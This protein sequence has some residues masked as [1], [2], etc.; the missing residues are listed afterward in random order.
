[1]GRAGNRGKSLG[2]SLTVFLAGDAMLVRPWSQVTRPAFQALIARMRAADAAILNLETVLHEFEDYAQADSGGTWTASQPAIAAELAWAGVDLLG[3]ANNHSFD[4]GAGGVLATHRHAEKAG[5]LIAGSGRDLQ[6]ARAPRCLVR[7]GGV[8]ALV[9]AAA[10]FVRYG[11]AS[12]SRADMRGRPGVN[13]LPLRK[14]TILHA[15]TGL[16]RLLRRAGRGV[17]LRVAKGP[18]LRLERGLRA[19]SADL[20]ANL[21]AIR[22]AAAT[23][24]VA[25]F[26]LHAHQHGKWL[27]Q[28]AH[29]A[30]EA[31]A[32][33]VLVHGP[34]RV[35]GVELYKGS[36]IFYGLGDFAYEPHCIDRF[37][38]EIYR[39]DGL[40]PDA[41][42]AEVRA[43]VRRSTLSQ[44]RE[45]FEGCAAELRFVEGRLSDV[46]LLPLDLG[47]DLGPEERGRPELA[48]SALGRRII[49][50]MARQSAQYRARVV[51]DA[52]RNEGLVD[53]GG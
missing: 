34:H 21:A 43:I 52:G 23:S 3:H 17:G 49:A 18:R 29:R 30:V 2:R 28:T 10:T 51:W 35:L 9:A 13:P 19:G 40:A 11:R 36:A 31:G 8:L 5:L 38:A 32:K 46:R 26:S 22:A 27:R 53:L 33:V 45:T 16:H 6:A 24:D 12:D 20:D 50:S 47:F 44:K 1:M 15:P 4:Y 41:D 14:D 7:T 39:H 37:P 48:G 25:V 42:A